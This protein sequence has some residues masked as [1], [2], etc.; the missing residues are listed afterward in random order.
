MQL[1]LVSKNRRRYFT[2]IY[3]SLIYEKIEK[4]NK[5]KRLQLI[6]K[7]AIASITAIQGCV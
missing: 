5:S 2:L 7:Q 4:K 3:P 1:F 6:F